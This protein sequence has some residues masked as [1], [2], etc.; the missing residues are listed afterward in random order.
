LVRQPH[1]FG[2]FA[3]D[4]GRSQLTRGGEVVAIGQRAAAILARL[5]QANG[6]VVSKDDLFTAAWPG[7]TVEESN[8]SVQIAALR[9]ALGQNALGEDW[10]MTA[11]RLGYRFATESAK[12]AQAPQANVTEKPAIAVL[13]FGNSSGEPGQDF[14]A[15]GLTEDII[16]D[17][18][19]VP[20]FLVIARNSTLVYKGKPTDVR[21]IAQDLGVNY[22]VEGNVRKSADRVRVNVQLVDAASGTHIWAERFD[23]EL[24]DV[25][26]LQDEVAR[27]IV[28]AIS[29][30]LSSEPLLRKRPRSVE[31][32]ELCLRCR[33][34]IAQS[35]EANEEAQRFLLRAIELEPR[36]SEAHRRLAMSYSFHWLHYDADPTTYRAKSLAAAERA[37]ELD[38]QDSGA[39]WVLSWIQ[40][41]ERLPALAH[42]NFVKAIRLNPND[43]DAHAMFGDFLAMEGKPEQAIDAINEGLRL[44]PRPGG[45]YYWLLGQALVQLG[46]YE[47]AVEALNREETYRSNS[48]RVLAVALSKLGRSEEA[49]T[50]A[51]LFMAT[52]PGA[53]T[54]FWIE[55]RPFR[56]PEDLKFWADA[57]TEVGLPD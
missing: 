50:E 1:K 53:R 55:T 25:F 4:A 48:R 17:L 9:K 23:R 35:K 12:N 36:Y 41:Y 51:R 24:P 31:A 47:E 57:F 42:A 18:S 28:A 27:R 14:F 54:R 15:D 56:R 10:I 3:F 45:W 11:Q 13:P 44:N 6:G 21:Q 49:S 19:N 37:V 40:A 32:Y 34:M 46:R 16:T 52:A 7:Q 2:A 43:A 20:N 22:I 38:P 5:L 8:L 29:G 39:Y 26:A 30:K 33:Y